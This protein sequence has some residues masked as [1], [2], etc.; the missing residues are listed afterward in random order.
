MYIYLLYGF[1]RQM[2]RMVL[3]YI[4]VPIRIVIIYWFYTFKVIA[5]IRVTNLCVQLTHSH[6]FKC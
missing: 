5:Y 4:E 6:A 1:M 3:I 2:L